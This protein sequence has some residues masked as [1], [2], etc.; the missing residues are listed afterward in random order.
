MKTPQ[1]EKERLGGL[2]EEQRD[3]LHNVNSSGGRAR[4]CYGADEA[5]DAFNWYMGMESKVGPE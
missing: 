4:V 3:F 2:T 1:R 5:I